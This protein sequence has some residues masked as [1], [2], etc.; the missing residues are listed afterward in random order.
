MRESDGGRSTGCSASWA[1]RGARARLERRPSRRRRASL[2]GLPDKCDRGRVRRGG[3]VGGAAADDDERDFQRAGHER[4]RRALRVR[5]GGGVGEG[6]ALHG[7][8]QGCAVPRERRAGAGAAAVRER[9]ERRGVHRARERPLCK[10]HEVVER[11]LRLLGVNVPRGGL[12]REPPGDVL[13]GEGGR[14][15]VRRGRRL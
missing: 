4:G 11:A 13:R 14:P 7:R 10:V 15:V 12:P 5:R 9:L 8:L 1:Q 2:Y 3:G 6:R